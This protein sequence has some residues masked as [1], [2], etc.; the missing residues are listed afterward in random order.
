MADSEER[1]EGEENCKTGS[2]EHNPGAAGSDCATLIRT[3]MNMCCRQEQSDGSEGLGGGMGRNA[4][5]RKGAYW[6]WQGYERA[7]GA[8][9][10]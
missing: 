10:Q 3:G 4:N 5:I 1:R 9:A 8:G 7:E 6:L 2:K